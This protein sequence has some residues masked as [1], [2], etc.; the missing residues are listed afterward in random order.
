MLG[1]RR[2][3]GL[4]RRLL[5]LV[6]EMGRWATREECR[7]KA[8]NYENEED[9]GDNSLLTLSAA[10]STSMGVT[11]FQSKAVWEH[12]LESASFPWRVFHS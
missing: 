10:L 12:I 7:L 6:D 5:P 2:V 8:R 11:W 9:E 3:R 1:Q 4:L